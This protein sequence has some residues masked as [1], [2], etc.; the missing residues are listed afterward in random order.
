MA[1]PH[2]AAQILNHL[3]MVAAPLAALL[4]TGHD[5]AVGALVTLG[6]C[7]AVSEHR[8]HRPVR[9]R[10]R[11]RTLTGA[12]IVATTTASL[13]PSGAVATGATFSAVASALA[14]GCTRID[15]PHNPAVDMWPVPTPRPTGT[16]PQPTLGS[17]APGHSHIP[18]GDKAQV[19]LRPY[20]RRS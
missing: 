7:A 5:L 16:E 19:R 9:Q 14:L 6:C 20:H 15:P 1:M 12:Y 13:T 10:W 18:A 11:W 3:H 8:H 4:L 2:R 17:A